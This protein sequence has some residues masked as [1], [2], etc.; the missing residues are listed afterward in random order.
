MYL[1][2]VLLEVGDQV[3]P[4]SMLDVNHEVA[5]VEERTGPCPSSDRRKPS[6][7][8]GCISSGSLGIRTAYH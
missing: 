7:Y 5:A 4:I 3:V 6:W 1:F 8:L 2:G